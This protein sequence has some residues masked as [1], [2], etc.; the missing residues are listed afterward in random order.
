M[1]GHAQ[2]AES[3]NECPISRDIEEAATVPT[4]SRQHK[5]PLSH[6]DYPVKRRKSVVPHRERS[7][8]RNQDAP[9]IKDESITASDDEDADEIVG[10]SFVSEEI[11]IGDAAKV[12]EVI[13]TRLRQMKQEYCKKVAK[14]WIKAKE[15]LKQTKYPYNG[16]ATKEESIMRFGDEMAGELSK[17]PWWCDTQGWQRGEGCR[18]KE[19][20]HQKKPGT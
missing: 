19:P 1:T 10:T 3:R 16:G 9:R 20:D 12:W 15:P 13:D 8:I 18:H 7:Q 6:P 4:Q 17:P 5:R 14:V 11:R 2:C